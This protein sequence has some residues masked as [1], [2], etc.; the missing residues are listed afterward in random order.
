M[1]FIG[2]LV[3]SDTC[4]K[5]FTSKKSLLKHL[6]THEEGSPFACRHCPEVFPNRFRKKRHMKSFHT[7]QRYMCTICKWGTNHHSN[8][9]GHL[10]THAGDR[11]FQCQ[12]CKKRFYQKGHLTT[13][14]E[15]VRC[16]KPE[17]QIL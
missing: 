15:R 17:Y 13:H 5:S 8:F 10:R 12:K 7:K 1:K 9:E 6:K 11:P 14:N 4:D 3:I 16:Q 2:N